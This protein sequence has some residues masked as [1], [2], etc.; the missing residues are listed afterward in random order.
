MTTDNTQPDPSGLGYLGTPVIPGSQ[1][2]VHDPKR[3]QPRV[4]TPGKQNSDAPSDA[5]VLFDGTSLDGWVKTSDGSPAQWKVENG[6]MEVAP[7]TGNIQT[8]AAFGDC[9]LHVEWA[10]PTEIEGT[11]QGRGNSGVFLMG[12]Y[13]VQVLDNY[14]NPTYPDGTV[15][16]LYG[17]YPPLV[18]PIRE[19]GQWQ[20]YDIIWIAPRFE[21]EKLIA[22][23][24]ITV[25]FNG[26][27]IH[28]DQVLPFIPGHKAIFPYKAHGP[29]GPLM[30]Q[31][32][33]N[34]VR[35]RNI[36]YRPL[37]GYDE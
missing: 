6:Y 15:G 5:I 10:S 4:V 25:I 3:P 18:N 37:K 17:L 16:S 26:V 21:G 22:P 27:V 1:Y 36:W 11:G 34:P 9:Q 19:P 20:T 30:L 23:A 7:R 35:F 14:N 8:K 13:E 12:I 33:R 2:H 31:D 32:H 24:R 29:V 28:H